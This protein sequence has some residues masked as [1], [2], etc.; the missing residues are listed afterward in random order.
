MVSYLE[1]YFTQKK[2]E[3]HKWFSNQWRT[4]HVWNLL[5]MISV[6]R[7]IPALEPWNDTFSA[8][9]SSVYAVISLS[10]S[11]DV[12]LQLQS[13]SPRLILNLYVCNTVLR[14]DLNLVMGYPS[15]NRF[16]VVNNQSELDA[17]VSACHTVTKNCSQVSVR[18]GENTSRLQR[19]A[20]LQHRRITAGDHKS[21]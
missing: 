15:R 3:L 8:L 11:K 4:F 5:F 2:K 9:T 12:Q 17:A 10:I 14:W 20:K 18:V 7:A 19:S 16:T 1:K 6:L 21:L 13:G